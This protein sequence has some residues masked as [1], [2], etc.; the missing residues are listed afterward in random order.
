MLM[1]IALIIIGESN[2]CLGKLLVI[3]ETFTAFK[4]QYVETLQNIVVLLPN[5]LEVYMECYC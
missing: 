2:V 3:L 1:T 4:K 5:A